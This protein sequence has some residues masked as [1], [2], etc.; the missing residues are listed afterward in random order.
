MSCARG[1]EGV[2]DMLAFG[3]VFKDQ[4]MLHL[5]RGEPFTPPTSFYLALFLD[6]PT[7]D[8]DTS[9]EV[10]GAA[11]QRQ[12]IK[13]FKFLGNGEVQNDGDIAFPVAA[14]DWGTITH[15]AVVD[16]L[17][18]MVYFAKFDIPKKIYRGDQFYVRHGELG[19]RLE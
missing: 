13:G 6:D 17:G 11:Y 15:Y 10:T 2:N 5:F 7:V 16:E 8:F 4:L 9:K 1:C 3:R 12:K 18:R 14:D 19:A